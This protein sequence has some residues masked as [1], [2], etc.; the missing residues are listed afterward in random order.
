MLYLFAIVFPPLAVLLCGKPLQAALNVLLTLCFWV[1]GVIHAILLVSSHHA[2]LRT[3]RV[4]RAVTGASEQKHDGRTACPS[5]GYRN[6][7]SRKTCKQCRVQM[8]RV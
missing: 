6:S 8:G 2:D 1:P 7:A 4:V 5:C 3:G